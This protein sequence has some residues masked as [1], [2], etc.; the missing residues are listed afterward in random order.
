MVDEAVWLID[1]DDYFDPWNVSIH[2]ITSERVRGL[3]RFCDL[4]SDLAS[5]FKESIVVHHDPFDRVAIQRACSRYNLGEI[6][7]LWLD[8]QRVVRRAWNEF[9]KSGYSLRNLAKVFEITFEAHDALEDARATDIIFRRAVSETG[10]S[11]IE[12]L[13]HIHILKRY[14]SDS[15]ERID[16]TGNEQGSFAGETIVF[17]GA[18]KVPRREAADVAQAIGFNI[19]DTVTKRTTVLCVGIQDRD[20]LAGYEKSSKQRKAEAMIRDGHD[21]SIISESD[22]WA[23]IKSANA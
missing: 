2:G 1:P 18:L 21:I 11:P 17:T 19:E 7:P 5:R 12:W 15:R 20:K 14:S 3:P 22:F 23:L 6:N 10:I 8:N 13:D 16:R 4:H 9:S